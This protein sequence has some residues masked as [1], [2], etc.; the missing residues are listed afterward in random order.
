MIWIFVLTKLFSLVTAKGSMSGQRVAQSK[1]RSV[2][3]FCSSFGLDIS[4][5]SLGERKHMRFLFFSFPNAAAFDAFDEK[6]R[7]PI[8]AF[9]DDS[10]WVGS[11][12]LIPII[13]LFTFMIT[14]VCAKEMHHHPQQGCRGTADEDGG[15]GRARRFGQHGKRPL[16]HLRWRRGF[17]FVSVDEE[18]SEAGRSV[19][20][21]LPF[22]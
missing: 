16:Y 4:L 21:E 14:S 10:F 5:V 19:G 11:L 2:S 13:L 17:S 12:T 15:D 9:V 1:K 3:D 8:V 7:D 18:K 22:D 20:C 6:M